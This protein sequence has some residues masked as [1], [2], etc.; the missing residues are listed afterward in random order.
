MN[1]KVLC[2]AQLS[3]FSVSVAFI[4]ILFSVSPTLVTTLEIT[5]H[6]E[7]QPLRSQTKKVPVP[8]ALTFPLLSH[9][10]QCWTDSVPLCELESLDL[11][12]SFICPH[13]LIWLSPQEPPHPPISLI[14]PIAFWLPQLYT[15]PLLNCTV[16]I[17]LLLAFKHTGENPDCVIPLHLHAF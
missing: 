12:P 8:K 15:Q 4:Y 10:H 14:H 3:G 5:Q 17:F 6:S 1:W 7:A 11:P 2:I 13:Y 16:F 9:S